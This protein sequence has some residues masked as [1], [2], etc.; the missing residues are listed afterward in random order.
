MIIIKGNVNTI[1]IETIEI[2]F[3]MIFDY[4]GPVV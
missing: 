2:G 3:P 4:N 1:Y